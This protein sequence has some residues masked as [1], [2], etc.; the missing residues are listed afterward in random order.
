M[1]NSSNNRLLI[2]RIFKIALCFCLASLPNYGVCQQRGKRA[3]SKR[4]TSTIGGYSFVTSDRI[5]KDVVKFK[6]ICNSSGEPDGYGTLTTCSQNKRVLV[7]EVSGLFRGNTIS[8]ATMTLKGESEYAPAVFKGNLSFTVS[9]VGADNS[10]WVDYTLQ[11]GILYVEDEPALRVQDGSVTFRRGLH[12][13]GESLSGGGKAKPFADPYSPVSGLVP[14]GTFPDSNIS[15]SKSEHGAYVISGSHQVP[16]SLLHS[17]RESEVFTPSYWLSA[18]QPVAIK[19]TFTEM[20]GCVEKTKKGYKESNWDDHYHALRTVINNVDR[21]KLNNGSYTFAGE[22]DG[23]FTILETEGQGYSEPFEN[24]IPRPQSS[25]TVAVSSS[26]LTITNE[27]QIQITEYDTGEV[28]VNQARPSDKVIPSPSHDDLIFPPAEET[29]RTLKN[30]VVYNIPVIFFGAT[31]NC[32]VSCST[33]MWATPRIQGAYGGAHVRNRTLYGDPVPP[34]RV[35]RVFT[36]VIDLNELSKA[37]GVEKPVL[38]AILY[39]HFDVL[40]YPPTPVFQTDF[41][42]ALWQALVNPALATRKK[43]MAANK[44]KEPLSAIGFYTGTGDLTAATNISD[45]LFR[46]AS[47]IDELYG[48]LKDI[49]PIYCASDSLFAERQPWYFFSGMLGIP[50]L[51]SKTDGSGKVFF[52]SFLERRDELLKESVPTDEEL[53]EVY[54]KVSRQ[55]AR[56][57]FKELDIDSITGASPEIVDQMK[58]GVVEGKLDA[59][60]ANPTFREGLSLLDFK[61]YMEGDTFEK[62]RSYLSAAAMLACETMKNDIIY[63]WNSRDTEGAV[64]DTRLLQALYQLMEDKEEYS[65]LVDYAFLSEA[66][67]ALRGNNSQSVSSPYRPLLQDRTLAVFENSGFAASKS[68]KNPFPAIRSWTKKFFDFNDVDLPVLDD[69]QVNIKDTPVAEDLNNAANFNAEIAEKSQKNTSQKSEIGKAKADSSVSESQFVRKGSKLYLAGTNQLVNSTDFT[70]SSAW[71]QYQ[72]GSS[73]MN[74]SKYLFIA[75]G[76]GLAL[77][78]AGLGMMMGDDLTY[79]VGMVSF[80]S[81][82]AV[83]SVGAISGLILR[84]SGKSKIENAIAIET[85]GYASEV[86]FGLQQYGVGIALTF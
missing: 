48:T 21:V 34:Y 64:E 24:C 18:Q 45:N 42:A 36:Y 84:M 62:L 78:G 26:K 29:N 41:G 5:E 59:F 86:S 43:T 32:K 33:K 14:L 20:A 49:Y 16:A 12:A 25:G 57:Q 85:N 73:Q 11:D 68:T 74:A 81:G 53:S 76:V 6:G 31:I 44:D 72:K 15:I 23:N 38:A 67:N 46:K 3:A 70:N 60:V 22:T 52:N 77:G 35:K 82:L 30:G 65:A 51:L 58:F 75:S 19:S 83:T 71:Q 13:M 69:I 37:M 28:I 79:S 7:D 80:I 27:R 1:T 2:L 54:Y 66:V 63:E 56:K 47:S 55:M 50:D 39:D 17:K 4:E 10:I 61:D 8:Y 40:A 9:S